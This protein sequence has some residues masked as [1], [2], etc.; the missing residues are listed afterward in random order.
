MTTL[1]PLVFSVGTGQG[2]PEQSP[3]DPSSE[4]RWSGSWIDKWM[5][6][7]VGS[8]APNLGGQPREDEASSQPENKHFLNER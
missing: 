4:G 3:P 5:N 6:P 1:V 2:L 8:S 7:E